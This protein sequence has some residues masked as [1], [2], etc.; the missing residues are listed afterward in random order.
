MLILAQFLLIVGL[1]LD[2]FFLPKLEECSYWSWVFL[3]IWS[4]CKNKNTASAEKILLQ[5][6]YNETWMHRNPRPAQLTSRG[7]GLKTNRRIC[8]VRV[9]SSSWRRC[10]YSSTPRSLAEKVCVEAPGQTSESTRVQR[11]ETTRGSVCCQT[12]GWALIQIRKIPANI[13]FFSI[14]SQ[15]NHEKG[16]I[17]LI[18]LCGRFEKECPLI[19]M[20]NHPNKEVLFPRLAFQ[21]KC[22]GSGT[23]Y[24]QLHPT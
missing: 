12:L 18:R 19:L 4:V 15:S 8:S 16:L 22:F 10:S 11:V 9:K 24:S 21:V 20:K 5:Q 23:K 14:P 17:S 2:I 6:H 13:S 3:T 1:K 7:G